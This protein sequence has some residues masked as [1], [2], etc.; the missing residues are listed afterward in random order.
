MRLSYQK[1]KKIIQG[2]GNEKIN[3]K[4]RIIEVGDLNKVFNLG[5]NKDKLIMN[6]NNNKLKSEI[7]NKYFEIYEEIYNGILYDTFFHYWIHNECLYKF[8]LDK[9]NKKDNIANFSWDNSNFKATAENYLLL[10]ILILFLI[11]KTNI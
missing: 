2:I 10:K 8:K 5:I 9:L 1:Q 6:D 11:M 3:Q 4:E 7:R